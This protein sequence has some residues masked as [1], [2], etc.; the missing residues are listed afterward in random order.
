MIQIISQEILCEEQSSALQVVLAF[1][2]YDPALLHLAAHL[3]LLHKMPSVKHH[4]QRLSLDN[5]GERGCY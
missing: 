5:Q 3:A 4:A 2:L 1:L